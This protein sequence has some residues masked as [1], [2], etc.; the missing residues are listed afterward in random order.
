MKTVW[1]TGEAIFGL[2]QYP[3]NSRNTGPNSRSV[4]GYKGVSLYTVGPQ[5]GLYVVRIRFNGKAYFGGY[6]KTLIE[7]AE[8]YNELAK[9]YHGEFAWLNK[10]NNE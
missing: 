5:A 3:E 8:S 2:P 7:A 4:T 9:K 6:F 10:I 1:I